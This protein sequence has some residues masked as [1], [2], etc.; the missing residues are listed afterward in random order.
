MLI[1]TLV[2]LTLKILCFFVQ[3]REGTKI[4]NQQPGRFEV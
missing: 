1:K 3:A 4:Q 2:G